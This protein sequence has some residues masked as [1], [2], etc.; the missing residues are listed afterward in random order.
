MQH[1][2]NAQTTAGNVYTENEINAALDE[3]LA[4]AHARPDRV[5]W[6][7]LAAASLIAGT[8]TPNEAIAAAAGI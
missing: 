1:S 8:I 7:T 4:I 5:P 2:K 3:I 6:A